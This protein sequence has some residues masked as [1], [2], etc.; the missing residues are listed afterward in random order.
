MKNVV[1]EVLNRNQPRNKS[2]HQQSASPQEDL[3]EIYRPN[4][5][6]KK[7]QDRTDLFSG[8]LTQKP[9]LR[10]ETQSVSTSTPGELQWNKEFVQ[11]QGAALQRLSTAQSL[12]KLHSDRGSNDES[13]KGAQLIGKTRSQQFIWYFPQISSHLAEGAGSNAMGMVSGLTCTPGSLF[14][15]DEWLATTQGITCIP[16]SSKKQDV[17]PHSFKILASNQQELKTKLGEL[18]QRLNRRPLRLLT[19]YH[20]E[21]PSTFLKDSLQVSDSGSVAV[22]EGICYVN[23]I[24]LLD[25]FFHK[26]PNTSLQFD[27][28][29]N[30]LLLLGDYTIIDSALVKLKQ[31][32]EQL[33]S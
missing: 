19:A 9:N 4:Y 27:L 26:N 21:N 11:N 29:E 25:R 12:Q 28:R 10:P 6:R 32:A 5:Q 16:F 31:D 13:G 33:L 17:I 22:L 30:Y 18:F 24:A 2:Q 14:M 23:G 3:Q 8:A 7:Q 15:L 1:Q 20:S